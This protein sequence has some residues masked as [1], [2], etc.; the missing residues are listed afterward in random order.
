MYHAGTGQ[1][2]FL[3]GVSTSPSATNPHGTLFAALKPWGPWTNVGEIPGVNIS[4]FITKGAGPTTVFFTA[5]GGT[6][7]Y[8]LNVGRIDMVVSK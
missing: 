7:S 4:M 6:D 5:A 2:L 3:A 1:Y 8:N